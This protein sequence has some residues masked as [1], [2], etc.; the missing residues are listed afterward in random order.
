MEIAPFVT[1]YKRIE[2]CT[3]RCKDAACPLISCFAFDA[4]YDKW[5][6]NPDIQARKKYAGIIADTI[7]RRLAS[8]KKRE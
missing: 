6:S 7:E 8:V 5:A 2:Q 1:I 4:Y 3:D